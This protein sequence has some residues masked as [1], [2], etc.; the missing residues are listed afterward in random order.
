MVIFDE[1]NYVCAFDHSASIKG[2]IFNLNKFV[3]H[4]NKTMLK[5]IEHEFSLEL[6][7]ML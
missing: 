4:F 2:L 6:S 7:L 5:V 1:R 3:R